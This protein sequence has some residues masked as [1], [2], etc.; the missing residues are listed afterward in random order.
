MTLE[1]AT[2]NQSIGWYIF[3]DKIRLAY[4]KITEVEELKQNRSQTQKKITYTKGTIT[5]R[6]LI[7][8]LSG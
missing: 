6:I 5:I 3:C 7:L 2:V 4:F 8:Y 1:L